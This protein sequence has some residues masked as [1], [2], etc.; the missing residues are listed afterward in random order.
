MQWASE[1]VLC[2][3]CVKFKVWNYENEDKDTDWVPVQ[4]CKEEPEFTLKKTKDLGVVFS[5]SH[6]GPGYNEIHLA[7]W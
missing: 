6:L 5:V 7:T 4:D 2:Y 3:H 1:T